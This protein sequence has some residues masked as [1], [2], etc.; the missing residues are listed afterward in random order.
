MIELVDFNTRPG[1]DSG[2]SEVLDDDDNVELDKSN[3]LLMGPTG[4]GVTFIKIHVVPFF[5]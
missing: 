3:V 5:L 2:I 1:A 4:S